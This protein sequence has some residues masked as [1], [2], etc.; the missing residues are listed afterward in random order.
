MKKMLC[1]LLSLTLMLGIIPAAYASEAPQGGTLLVGEYVLDTQMA[2]LN[3]FVINGT[4]NE[5]LRQYMYDP[6]VYF[7]A[8]DGQFIPRLASDWAWNEDQSEITLTLREGVTFH[9]GEAFDADDV[10]FTLNMI[11]DTTL[12]MYGLWSRF[13]SVTGSGNQVTITCNSPYPSL[14]SYLHSIYIVPEHVWSGVGNVAEYLNEQPV[15]TGPFKFKSY[16]TGTD[17]QFDTN[18]SYWDGRANVDSLV[19]MMYNSSPNLSLALLSGEIDMTNG[20]ITMANIPEFLTK[21]NAQMQLYG[22]PNN[23]VV[24]FNHEHELL[25]DVAVRQAMCM[26]V[27]QQS[28]ITKAEYDGVFPINMGWLPEM[29]GDLVNAE[30]NSILSYDPDGAR[31]VLEAAGYTPGDDGIYQKDGNRLSFTYHNASG[32][33]AQQMEAG[34][35]QQWLLNIGIEIIPRLATWAELATLRQNGQFD[36]IQLSYNFPPD[37]FAALNSCFNSSQTAPS[38]E[39]SPGMNYFRYRNDELDALLEKLAV[40]TDAAAQKEMYYE[41]QMIIATDYVGIPM[42]NVGGHIPYY[43]GTRVSG[44]RTDVPAFSAINLTSVYVIQ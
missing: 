23:Y 31:A 43:D 12:D 28:L 5:S 21:E 15:G 33:P 32:A 35:I 17:I 36:L 1:I 27:D 13:E 38:G 40:E 9:D 19:I 6:L 39:A 42:Y 11:K 22:G 34:M 3:P 30:A 16:T 37:P 4:W 24:S 18:E 10:V 7:N 26:A 44:W 2:N 14:L 29:F 8:I 41:A 25:K 20:T